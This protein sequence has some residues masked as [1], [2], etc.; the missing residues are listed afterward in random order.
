MKDKIS[1]MFWWMWRIH[2]FLSLLLS[3]LQ[4]SPTWGSRLW[5]KNNT[6]LEGKQHKNSIRRKL[7]SLHFLRLCM[8]P[9]N[10]SG[11]VADSL[12]S[13]WPAKQKLIGT[14]L[15]SK[16]IGKITCACWN[17][18]TKRKA[19]HRPRIIS[20]QVG[21]IWTSVWGNGNEY[22]L[23]GHHSWEEW[24][25]LGSAPQY[26]GPRCVALAYRATSQE[27]SKQGSIW[28]SSNTGPFRGEVCT[29]H[30]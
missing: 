12:G 14:S 2:K 5:K 8:S 1:F 10:R 16:N 28:C 18:R 23:L 13:P 20:C 19:G 22:T 17:C 3:K 15:L 27:R 7:F 25:Y 26:T 24:E 21:Y 9:V 29:S 6:W 30:K 4:W 11:T